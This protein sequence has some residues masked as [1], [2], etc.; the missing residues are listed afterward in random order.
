MGAKNIVKSKRAEIFGPIFRKNPSVFQLNNALIYIL[1]TFRTKHEKRVHLSQDNGRLSYQKWGAKP[2]FHHE[3][4]Q[5]PPTA[6]P[7][8]ATGSAPD[9]SDVQTT[10]FLLFP[11]FHPKTQVALWNKILIQ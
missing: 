5:L 4:G 3:G 6:P 11:L 10:Q 9:M 1:H 2:S 7:K 8:S